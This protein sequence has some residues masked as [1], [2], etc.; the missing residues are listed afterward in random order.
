[1]K[2]YISHRGNING[3]N[4]D[5]ENSPE[6]IK[7]AINKGYDVEVDV[8]YIDNKW[9]FGHDTP[10]YEVDLKI[11]NHVKYYNFNKLWFHCKNLESLYELSWH[12]KWMYKEINYFW[13]Q[14]DNFTLTSRQYIWTYPGNKLEYNSICVLPELSIY[15][16]DELAIC[17]GICSDNIEKYKLDFSY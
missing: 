16:N 7:E 8:W 10:Q 9:Y 6:Y 12:H 3:R 13:H 15:T 1:M 14:N 11:F 4:I 2:R 17:A 5:L